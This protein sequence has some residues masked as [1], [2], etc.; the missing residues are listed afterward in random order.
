MKPC[1]R[2]SK[3][4]RDGSLSLLHSLP[5]ESEDV[6]L[7]K[8]CFAIAKLPAAVRHESQRDEIQLIPITRRAPPKTGSSHSLGWTLL[9]ISGV[10]LWGLRHYTCGGRFPNKAIIHWISVEMR[11][12][13]L[14]T[15][16]LQW[17]VIC[18]VIKDLSS[19]QRREHKSHLQRCRP[20]NP[21]S[22]IQHRA[23]VFF[24]KLTDRIVTQF[25]GS[26]YMNE[27]PWTEWFLWAP[28]RLN[29]KRRSSNASEHWMI[30][31]LYLHTCMCQ[32][33]FVFHM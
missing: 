15:D 27:Q 6:R 30:L 12:C 25:R 23:E 26:F 18:A 11:F 10:I 9:R 19:S 5:C 1:G 20:E 14:C 29:D 21:C 3:I 24:H 32:V 2:W 16:E 33:D 13:W 8:T 28:D 7:P 31:I 22:Q 4:K 17:P